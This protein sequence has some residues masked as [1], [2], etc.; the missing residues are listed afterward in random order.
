MTEPSKI[1]SVGLPAAG[2]TAL[3]GYGVYSAFKYIS[4]L[5]AKKL[6]LDAANDP[7]L[8][9]ILVA[10]KDDTSIFM[11]HNQPASVRELTLMRERNFNMARFYD[12]NLKYAKYAGLAALSLAAIAAYNYFDIGAKLDKFVGSKN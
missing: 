11:Y 1:V 2:A 6:F 5:P 10:A 4:D 8:S 7:E 3:T 12:K 9:A